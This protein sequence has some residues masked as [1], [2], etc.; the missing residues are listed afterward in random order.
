MKIISTTLT[1][2]L[3]I[4]LSATAQVLPAST[5]INYAS[6]KGMN[7]ETLFRTITRELSDDAFG[8]RKPLTPYEAPTLDYIAARFKEVGLEPAA[9]G[10]Y[11]QKV[12]LLGVATHLKNNEVVVT[13]SKGTVKMRYW[14]D[15]VIWTLR[16]EKKLKIDKADFVFVGFGI[17]AP[18][19]GWDDYAGI[20]VKGKVVVMLVNDPGFYD[21]QLFRGKNMTYYGRW[22]YKFEE[23]GRQGAA[24]ALII[25]DTA[26]ASYGWS[27][28][29]N[30][31]AS[32]SLSLYSE[33]ENKKLVPYQGWVTGESAQKLFNAAGVSL[34]ESVAAAKKKG[35]QSFP[36]KLKTTIESTNDITFGESA[37]VAAILPGTSLKDEYIIY[38]AHWDHFGIGQPVAGDSIYNGAGDNATGVAALALLGK[39]F[40]ELSDR[41]KRSILF[42]AVTAEESGLL[43]SQYYAEHPLFPLEKT[44]VC[45]NMD[46]YADYF[47]T[48]DLVLSAAGHSETDRY[49]MDAA[50]TQGRTVVISNDNSSGGYYRSD[51][52]NF[53]K[54]G[55]PVVLAKGGRNYLD[56]EAARAYYVKY[57]QGK[58]TY[59]QPSDEYDDWWEL[60]GALEDI[61]LFYGIGL[62]L[63]NDGY[64]P[65]WYDGVEF[66][67]AREKK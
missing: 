6:L 58:Y 14:D 34:D 37:N 42:L 1:F 64:F 25:H 23:A 57:H 39:R 54:V 45:L 11:F 8:G 48:S 30:S 33:A 15:I 7:D 16:A 60:S 26:P 61:Y 27:V 63:A 18:E 29:Q 32:S 21:D 10:S 44:A 24:A 19:Y 35:F 5:G 62:R 53:A 66:K 41:P 56:P 2:L 36:L 9:G 17:H 12:P 51:H 13:G 55:V 28:V 43:G 22:V 31:R 50:A 46:S 38:S 52:F 47:R 67:A 49:V 3:A 40:K 65:K 4:S 59:H 20:D